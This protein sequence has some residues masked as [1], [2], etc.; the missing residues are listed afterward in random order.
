MNRLKLAGITLTLW[1]CAS[2]ASFGGEPI[3][4]GAILGPR[5]D[6]VIMN[7]V[8]AAM[9]MARKACEATVRACGIA[10]VKT[11]ALP[12]TLRRSL[13]AVFPK[14]VLERASLHFGVPLNDPSMGIG[15]LNTLGML[16][17]GG[18]TVMAMTFGDDVYMVFTLDSL[19]G[20]DEHRRVVA[21]EL[22]HVA[23]YQGLGYSEYKQLYARET[24]R[25][26]G[27]YED[28]ALEKEAFR[29]EDC[30]GKPGAR[31]YFAFF[32]SP[33][34]PEMV[35]L[36]SA[37]TPR[38]VPLDDLLDVPTEA[39]E[40]TAAEDHLPRK[41]TLALGGATEYAVGIA[42][43]QVLDPHGGKPLFV[44]SVGDEKPSTLLVNAQV[45]RGGPWLLAVRGARG[46]EVMWRTPE[47]FHSRRFSRDAL[48]EDHDSDGTLDVVEPRAD[49]SNVVWRWNGQ[50]FASN[51]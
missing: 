28:N 23:Q 3:S 32:S 37:S 26:Q 4:L 24:A 48:I 14:C 50:G 10:P 51:R 7:T 38:L 49:G 22:V 47:A 40:M 2:R 6:A 27:S 45:T 15:F 46:V 41:A 36:M 21:H 43:P 16:A 1:L 8:P 44:Y 39:V 42:P 35:V 30:L 33:D 9:D 19:E 34:V 20:S 29:F 25:G 13:E 12:E 5:S 31:A 17:S 18:G 11:T